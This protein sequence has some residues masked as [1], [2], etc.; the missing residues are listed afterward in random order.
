MCI[1]R[2]FNKHVSSQL[3][4][5]RFFWLFQLAVIESAQ[6]KLIKYKRER[7]RVRMV[8]IEREEKKGDTVGGMNEREENG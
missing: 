2:R 5:A 7:E 6:K 8:E 3:L 4:F 1:T